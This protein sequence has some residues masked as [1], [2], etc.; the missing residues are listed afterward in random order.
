MRLFFHNCNK[1]NTTLRHRGK[2]KA[3]VS[4][5]IKCSTM[6]VALLVVLLLCHYLADFC[7][8]LPVMIRAKADG[9]GIGGIMMHAAVH[10]MLMGV[11]LLFFGVRIKLLLLLIVI[12]WLSHFI[13][14]SAKGRVSVRWPVLSDAHKKPYWM[15][16]GFDQLLHQLVIVVI[17][18]VACPLHTTFYSS[19]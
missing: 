16:Y 6:E 17:W 2:R 11:C 15:L 3:S 4:L 14:D 8:T 7:L 13:I 10:A 1:E 18:F 12:E 9:R 19:H 5:R